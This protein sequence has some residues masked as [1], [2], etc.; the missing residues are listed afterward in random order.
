LLAT[1]SIDSSAEDITVAANGIVDMRHEATSTTS[2]HVVGGQKNHFINHHTTI[3]D[4]ADLTIRSSQ[5]DDIDGTARP[6]FLCP[7]S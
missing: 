6:V 7:S 5:Q 1:S 2:G 3:M 4:I